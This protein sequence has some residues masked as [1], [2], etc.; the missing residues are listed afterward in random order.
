M[1][2]AATPTPPATSPATTVQHRAAGDGCQD[3]VLRGNIYVISDKQWVEAL[4][5]PAA[6]HKHGTFCH[7]VE[8][9]SFTSLT[10]LER[11]ICQLRIK[12]EKVLKKVMLMV[13]KSNNFKTHTK[14]CL[15][16]IRKWE[17]K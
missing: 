16:N 6:V 9:Y 7:T 12:I 10:P 11:N 15:F 13:Y 1:H 3:V 14:K 4:R 8:Q 5:L 2:L 17:E